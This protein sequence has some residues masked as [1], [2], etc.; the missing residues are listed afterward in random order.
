[1]GVPRTSTRRA[2]ARPHQ[3]L[4][5]TAA[6]LARVLTPARALAALARAY[7]AAGAGAAAEAKSLGFAVD[8]GT[9]HVKAGG[10]PG[11][12]SAFVAKTNVNR[13][14]NPARSL[15]TVQGLAVLVDPA[16][17]R[18]LAV[19]DSAA[20]TGIRTAATAVLAA[21]R[22]LVRPPRIVAVIG[23]GALGAQM[24]RHLAAR[25]RPR[26]I[27]VFDRDPA[28]ARAFLAHAPRGTVLAA[29]V[30][31][32]LDG[33]GF[34]ATCTTATSPVVRHEMLRGPVFLAAIGADNPGKREIDA[35][36]MRA[37]A[38]VADDPEACAAGGEIRHLL[39]E[40]PG[41]DVANVVPLATLVAGRA[42]PPA[43]PVIVFDSTGSGLQDAATAWAA[44]RAAARLP[45]V[46]RIAFA[47]L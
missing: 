19:L 28:R 35:A 21:T 20:L 24:V 29:G 16:S 36:T 31:E 33:A 3:V 46:R 30:A 1:M 34:C 14:G 40:A 7:R 15:P 37:A 6:D 12:A 10:L 47:D 17:G 32:A 25:F 18:P 41:F 42:R 13:P 45:G 44:Y 43:A 11:T 8:G 22:V 39:A 26:E 23:C 5:L 38:L 27:R 4:L 2:G 9:I